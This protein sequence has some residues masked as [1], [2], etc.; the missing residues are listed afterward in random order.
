[1]SDYA[2]F[3][4]L[5]D[6]VKQASSRIE[7]GD[8]QTRQRIDAIEAS[9]NDL[10]RRAGRPDG[11]MLDSDVLEC[12]AANDLCRNWHDLQVPK[13]ADSA[14]YTPSSSEVEKAMLA[15][16][17]MK[18]ML[19]HGDIARLEVAERK[20]LT[21]FSFGNTGWIVSL[22]WPAKRSVVWSIPATSPGWSIT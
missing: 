10:Y 15:C 18:A 9:V 13:D 3:S 16:L 7:H 14:A 20:S 12:K 11:S 2:G 1:M 8:R 19:R 6:E 22:Q 5:V 21:S 4:D 17:A